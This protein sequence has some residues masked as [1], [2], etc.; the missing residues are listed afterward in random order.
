MNIDLSPCLV[1]IAGPS[2]V[3]KTSLS[4]RIARHFSTEIISADS[5]QF[6]KEM[7]IGTVRPAAEQ[8]REIP[9]HFVGHLSVREP[10]NV[11]RFETDVLVLLEELF[12]KHPLVIMTGG[13][14]LYIEAVCRG[15]DD[16]PDPDDA[17]RLQL[18]DLLHRQGIQGL[19]DRLKVL[20]PVYH[21]QVDLS[22]PNRLLRALEVCLTTGVPYSLLRK[23]EPKQRNFRII[24]IGLELSRGELDRRINERTDAMMQQ[25]LLAEVKQLVPYRNLNALNTVGYKE[26]F[27]HLDGTLSLEDAVR[28][29]RTSTR[30]YAKRQMTW[31]RKDTAMTWFHPD[32][33]DAIVRFI[34]LTLQK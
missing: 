28:K 29:I 14:G 1:V 21:G 4:I 15:I 11:S 6:Y 22:N 13:S 8:L 18:K 24:K 3:G 12:K 5:R 26:L 33:Y 34:N 2:A 10:Y 32:Q 16:L 20:D 9:H 7:I 30:R 31:F 19:Q 25:G 27:D 23:N 17:T